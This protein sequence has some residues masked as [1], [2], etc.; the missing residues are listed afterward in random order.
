MARMIPSI[1]PGD[2]TKES[3]EDEVYWALSTLPDEY[4]VIHSFRMLE[5]INGKRVSQRE[6]DFVIF[7][8][9]LGILCIEAKAGRIACKQ[10]EWFY[11]SGVSMRHGGP[12]RQADTFKWKLA[13]RFEDLG[14]KDLR[15]RCKLTHAVWLPSMGAHE[16]SKIDYS[17]EASHE[18]TLCRSDLSA[19]ETQIKRIMGMD[20]GGCE[21]SL[22]EKEADEV[23][24][25]VLLPEFDIVPTNSLDYA[26]NDYVFARLLDSQK[27]VLDFLQDQKTAVI[28]GAAGTGKTLIA[29]ERAKKA[30][31][32]GRVLFLCYNA[33]LKGSIADRCADIPNIDVY[34]VAGYAC[35]V[36]SCSEPDYD[37]LVETLLDQPEKFEYDHLVIDEGQ[38][39]GL[40]AIE[41]ALLLEAFKSIMDDRAKGTMYLFY[42][43]RQ[44]VQGSTMPGFLAN[45]DCKLTL[46]VNCR[47]TQSI[48]R[49]S[50]NALGGE[51]VAN[52]RLLSE[53][54][55]PPM[56]FASVE[57]SAQEAYVDSQIKALVSSGLENI[58][59][60]TCKTLENSALSGCFTRKAGK[61]R[62]KDGS[63]PVH[64]FRRFKGMEADA[65]IL[66]D[67]DETLWKD[68]EKDYEP[69]PGTVFYTGASRAKHELRIV[70]D[71]DEDGC[72]RALELMGVHVT[73]RPEK[74]F[75]NVLG[76]TLVR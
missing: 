4:T 57:C 15:S 7:H 40:K 66:I 45:A 41:G 8:R 27:R 58:V 59:V 42:D 43:K 35:K 49:S 39:F 74:K 73:R 26:Y 72:A 1:G 63:I 37:A 9:K 22:S 14:L 5:I 17:P 36:C 38:D 44:F 6:A 65:V 51:D 60:V 33:L 25:K 31:Q 16:L 75:A 67:V 28:N 69:D 10:G 32:S 18:I 64:T 3:R 11:Q 20:V 61:D 54:G 2:Y 76:A 71:M 68:P 23:L 46:Y 19:P 21:T 48:A 29:V 30:A 50:L 47:N 70:C 55:G 62:W 24:H 53:L 52:I 12:Y 56:L 34:T 13:N